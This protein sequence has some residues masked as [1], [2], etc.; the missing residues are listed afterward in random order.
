M[1]NKAGIKIVDNETIEVTLSNGQVHIMREPQGHAM[2]GLSLDMVR[3][4]VTDQV[5]P[6]YARICEPIVSRKQFETMG[7]SDISLLNAALDFFYADAVGKKEIREIYQSLYETDSSATT[8][9]ESGAT[10]AE[11]LPVNNPASLMEENTTVTQ[12]TV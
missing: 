11:S 10:P 7:L 3:A 5:Q 12:A 2:K 1:Q 9:G 4:K 6:L 8:A